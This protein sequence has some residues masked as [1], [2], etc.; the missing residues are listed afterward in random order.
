MYVLWLPLSKMALTTVLSCLEQ[1]LDKFKRELSE[2]EQ[3]FG[4]LHRM[5]WWCLG[6]SFQVQVEIH[7]KFLE[8]IRQVWTSQNL[9]HSVDDKL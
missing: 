7:Q 3:S 2:V 6:S 8:L 5:Y 9:A 4:C 1:G